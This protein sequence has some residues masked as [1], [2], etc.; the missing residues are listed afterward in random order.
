MHGNEPNPQRLHSATCRIARICFSFFWCQKPQGTIRGPCPD[1]SKLFW[2]QTRYWVGRWINVVIVV[3]WCIPC[4]N[5]PE[6]II[7]YFCLPWD[8]V[9][10]KC[11]LYSVLYTIKWYAPM[12]KQKGK[13]VIFYFLARLFKALCSLL[14]SLE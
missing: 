4:G 1:R 10:Q 2:W 7:Q 8:L 13:K 11:N 12:N 5:A 3:N 6:I 9:L 14:E